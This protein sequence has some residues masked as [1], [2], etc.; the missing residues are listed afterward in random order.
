M[1]AQSN[2]P[3]LSVSLM[4]GAITDDIQHISHLFVCVFVFCFFKV[5]ARAPSARGDAV[6]DIAPS[7]PLR[8]L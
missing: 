3:P 7:F 4:T 5:M 2:Q 1:M 6:I 8:E